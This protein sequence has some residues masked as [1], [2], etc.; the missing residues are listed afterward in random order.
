MNT[1]L[2]KNISLKNRIVDVLYAYVDPR[3]R[4]QYSS[5]SRKLFRRASKEVIHNGK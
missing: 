1:I 3:I 4:S 2:I 5:K